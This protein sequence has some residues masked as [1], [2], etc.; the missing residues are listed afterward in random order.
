M[1]KRKS[2]VPTL[3]QDQRID[4][5]GAVNKI[6]TPTKES[7]FRYSSTESIN[8]KDIFKDNLRDSITK[9]RGRQR[10]QSCELPSD[11]EDEINLT[12]ANET[13]EE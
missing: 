3:D 2:F 6:I 4:Y 1:S 10:V 7:V 9:S 13:H 5:E 11:D 12:N 8:V